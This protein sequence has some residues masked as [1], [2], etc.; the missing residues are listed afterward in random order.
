ML[1]RVPVQA[2]LGTALALGQIQEAPGQARVW[3]SAER[4]ARQQLVQVLVTSPL[5]ITA[6]PWF[7]YHHQSDT[8]RWD[9]R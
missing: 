5:P 1:V 9:C 2:E 4:P 6:S 7:P 8:C 3:G